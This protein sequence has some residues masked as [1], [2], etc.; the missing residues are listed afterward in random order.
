MTIMLNNAILANRSII[1]ISG[2]NIT[3]WLEGIIPFQIHNANIIWTPFLKPQGKVLF[4]AFIIKNN[5]NYY[6]DVSNP[7]QAYQVLNKYIIIEDIELKQTAW[8]IMVSD[9]EIKNSLIS[10][11]DPRDGNIFRSIIDQDIDNK[12]MNK[13]NLIPWPYYRIVNL[14]PEAQDIVGNFLPDITTLQTKG[15]CWVGQEVINTI[16]KKQLS[17]KQLCSIATNTPITEANLN[18]TNDKKINVGIISS[19]YQYNGENVAIAMIKKKYLSTDKLSLYYNNI[20]IKL[21]KC[22]TS[23]S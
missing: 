1:I 15:G 3:K 22:I 4:D 11:K 23:Q 9:K 12:K 18:I 21:I 20:P 17:K 8:Q 10:L 19:Y 2:N 16:I 7:K 13:K 6:L 5:Q 14:L